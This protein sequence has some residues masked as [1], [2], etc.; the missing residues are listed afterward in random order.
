M[1]A[2]HRAVEVCGTGTTTAISIVD[3]EAKLLI[4]QNLVI[5]LYGHDLRGCAIT[6][7]LVAHIAAVNSSEVGNYNRTNH[8]QHGNRDNGFPAAKALVKHDVCYDNC[9]SDSDIAKRAHG[10]RDKGI[11]AHILNNKSQLLRPVATSQG[12]C[13]GCH[14]VVGNERHNN[15]H[16]H[17]NATRNTEGDILHLRRHLAT[18][19]TP[20]SDCGKEWHTPL[21]NYERHR[22]GA[23]IIVGGE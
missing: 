15:D 9:R 14:A 16:Q 8:A 21:H 10:I 2:I 19:Q 6:P 3:A 7:L 18:E 1:V 17:H 13:K 12:L 23:E 11:A 5:G 4:S 22:H 20:Q